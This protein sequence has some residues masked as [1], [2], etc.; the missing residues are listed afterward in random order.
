MGTSFGD[1]PLLS[2]VTSWQPNF[3]FVYR[4]RFSKLFDE[5][6]LNFESEH[7]G[8]SQSQNRGI[9]DGSIEFSCQISLGI[10]GLKYERL[11]L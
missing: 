11:L 1:Q 3:N 7:S 9:F 6:V 10:E 5:K 8:V 2:E 4:K